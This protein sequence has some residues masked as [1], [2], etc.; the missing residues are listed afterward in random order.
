M[1]VYAEIPELFATYQ[2]LMLLFSFLCNI[3]VCIYTLYIHTHIY[4]YIHTHTYTQTYL[5]RGAIRNCLVRV[6]AL[7]Q[8]LSVKIVLKHLM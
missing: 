1:Y 2:P 5:N 6:D 8:L 7:V 4:I 3:Y